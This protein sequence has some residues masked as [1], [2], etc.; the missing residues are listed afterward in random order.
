MTVGIKLHFR[1][2]VNRDT[3]A[4][5]SKNNK[6]CRIHA[7]KNKPSDE[8]NDK[9]NQMSYH[10]FVHPYGGVNFKKG[11]DNTELFV[12]PNKKGMFG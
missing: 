2:K 7:G 10:S 4:K 6:K 3:A 9:Q 5:Y 11:E 12:Q 8:E 1:K